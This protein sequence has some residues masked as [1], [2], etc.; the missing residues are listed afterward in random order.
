MEPEGAQLGALAPVQ[1]GRRSWR[2][3]AIAAVLLL[4][5]LAGQTTAGLYLPSAWP[6]VDWVL[7]LALAWAWRRGRG[8]GVL[9]ALVGGLLL[10]LASAGPPGLH[11][12]ALGLAL[13]LAESAGEPVVRGW[14]GRLLVAA[15]AGALVH[16]VLLAGLWLRG[17]L[18]DWSR[19]LAQATLPA[20]GAD[21][22]VVIVLYYL[23]GALLAPTVPA[24]SR[25]R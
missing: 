5:A 8:E 16:L 17:W 14:P 15:C 9:V 11:V 3:L 12:L 10:D 23:V 24:P 21:L 20:V 19:V 22:I 25:G 2:R 4:A 7:A 1:G 18:L 6:R 13:L